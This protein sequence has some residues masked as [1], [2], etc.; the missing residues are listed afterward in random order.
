MLNNNSALCRRVGSPCAKLSNT[1]CRH[2]GSPCAQLSSALN[3]RM[4][5][6][7]A[8]LSTTICRRLGSPCAYLSTTLCRC[9]GSK[10]KIPPLLT[11]SLHGYKWMDSL[12][13]RF[14][15]AIGLW[16]DAVEYRKSLT[17]LGNK[18]S[19]LQPIIRGCRTEP[20]RLIRVSTFTK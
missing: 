11:A 1:L 7:C 16:V 13:C 19:A 6:L 18:N 15:P 3:K 14:T 12:S 10:C 9:I 5:G 2:L 20:S 4:G 17:F 8:Q